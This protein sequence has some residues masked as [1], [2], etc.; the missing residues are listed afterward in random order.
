M[1]GN[2]TRLFAKLCGTRRFCR[3]LHM[4]TLF[5]SCFLL[6][7]F[8]PAIRTVFIP[9]NVSIFSITSRA[10]VKHFFACHNLS[11]TRPPFFPISAPHRGNIGGGDSSYLF[12]HTIDH[13]RT[14]PVSAQVTALPLTR[15]AMVFFHLAYKR[16]PANVITRGQPSC[17]LCLNIALPSV[18]SGLICKI[19][20]CGIVCPAH[21]TPY[22]SCVYTV[23][24]LLPSNFIPQC[25]QNLIISTSRFC[26]RY[27]MR[28]PYVN[29]NMRTVAQFAPCAIFILD[30]CVQYGLHAIFVYLFVCANLFAYAA[31]ALCR[32]IH[33][34]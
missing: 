30:I 22:L 17:S 20:P 18:S 9:I 11:Y 7:H 19:R 5:F 24:S 21:L 4:D 2:E 27:H 29:L 26:Y 12:K 6:I 32:C 25:Q 1:T 23:L 3:N 16:L 31:V 14:A 33:F 8:S 10:T 13:A 34:S 15:G 28:A